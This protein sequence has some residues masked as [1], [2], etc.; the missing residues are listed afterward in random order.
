M[1]CKNC[2]N[3]LDDNA[4]FCGKCG[5]TVNSEASGSAVPPTPVTPD[6]SGS[7][8]SANTIKRFLPKI[9]VLIGLICF[10]FPFMSVSCASEKVNVTGTDMI[11]GD[12]ETSQSVKNY[13][14]DD[15]KKGS[16]FNIFVTASGICAIF[17]FFKA[18]K[19]GLLSAL[20]LIVFRLSAKSYYRI[21]EKKLSELE[22]VFRIEFGTAL[23]IAVIMFIAAAVT[24]YLIQQ[25]E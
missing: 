5:T 8:A 2:G 22:D 15:D 14:G 16:L 10:F 21:G 11:F 12:K 19:T 3:N 24:D 7:T 20:F 4:K 6:S 23:W 25:K 13:L 18:K 9:L 17:S 1:F